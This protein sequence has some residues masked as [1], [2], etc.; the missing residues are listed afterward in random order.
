MGILIVPVH[1]SMPTGNIQTVLCWF[2]WCPARIIELLLKNVSPLSCIHCLSTSALHVISGA[3]QL[4][5]VQ[6]GAF[7]GPGSGPI[8]L[9]KVNCRGIEEML[10]S[11]DR[12]SFR[13]LTSCTHSRDV[14][15]RCPGQYMKMKLFMVT[16]CICICNCV[17]AHVESILR[18][19]IKYTYYPGNPI[20][21]DL[22]F[23]KHY[24]VNADNVNILVLL[25]L[26]IL[27]SVNNKTFTTAM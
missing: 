19:F 8:Y 20:N 27:M 3:T 26:Q 25:L 18:V 7:Y 14:G 23:C 5:T 22:L 6:R 11:C 1:G 16:M 10:L 15:V 21:S 9:E 24:M 2:L 12:G 13:G 4:P 17:V